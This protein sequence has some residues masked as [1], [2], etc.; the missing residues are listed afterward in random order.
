MDELHDVQVGDRV[1]IAHR[2]GWSGRIYCLDVAEVEKVTRT[3]ITAF[4]GR[5]LIRTGRRVGEISRYSADLLQRLTP[6]IEAEAAEDAAISAAEKK[7]RLWAEALRRARNNDAV[8]FAAMLPDRAAAD[9][10]E[11]GGE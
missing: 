7:C 3:Q 10:A 8:R 11:G 4:G 1:C 6:E 2:A 9:D 5:W